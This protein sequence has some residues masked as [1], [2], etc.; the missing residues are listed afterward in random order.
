G[1]IV[2]GTGIMLN[3]M[4]GE[5]ELLPQGPQ[6]LEPGD[7]LPSNMTPMIAQRDGDVIAMGAAGADR[8]APAIAQVWRGMAARGQSAEDSIRSP[9]F[10]VRTVDGEVVVDYEPGFDLAGVEWS[11][12]AFDAPHMYFGGVQAAACKRDG[13]LDGGGDPRRGGAIA[14]I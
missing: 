14:S 9:R 11:L 12:H 2:P 10:H 7:R 13:T 6:V 8:I 4:L 1:V 3:N 5:L